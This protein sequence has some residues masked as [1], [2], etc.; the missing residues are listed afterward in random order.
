M[1]TTAQCDEEGTHTEEDEHTVIPEIGVVK[2]TKVGPLC[3]MAVLLVDIEA[4]TSLSHLGLAVVTEVVLE[5]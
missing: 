5:F 3:D 1:S 4:N 2:Y